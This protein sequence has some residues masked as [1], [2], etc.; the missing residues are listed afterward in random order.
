[1]A[2]LNVDGAHPAL[3][4][5][6]S[7]EQRNSAAVTKGCD[8]Q[9]AAPPLLSLRLRFSL[10][11]RR[12]ALTS[13]RAQLILHIPFMGTVRIKAIVVRDVDRRRTLSEKV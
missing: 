5:L 7:H 8:E 12:S 10:R 9:V 1:V 11:L 13:R 4:C 2:G 6:K 3:N